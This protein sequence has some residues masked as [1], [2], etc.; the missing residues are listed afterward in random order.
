MAKT[1]LGWNALD[2]IKQQLRADSVRW[3]P[4]YATGAAAQ[5]LAVPRL[6]GIAQFNYDPTRDLDRIRVPTLVIVGERDLVF[7]PALVVER[8]ERALA[9]AGNRC[10][11]SRVIPQASHELHR[12]QT[13]RGRPFR[14][15][16]SEEFLRTLT[17][18]VS[19]RPCR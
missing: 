2:S 7:P 17:D 19:S 3:F 15:A 1:G 14:R 10:V 6:Y 11:T 18:W 16:I 12:V 9:R 4:G 5:S 8:M 13:F